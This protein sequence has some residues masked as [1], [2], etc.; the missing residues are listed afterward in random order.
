MLRAF[1]F[2]FGSL[3]VSSFGFAQEMTSPA[4]LNQVFYEAR[5]QKETQA[6]IDYIDDA[7]QVY[8]SLA[9]EEKQ[10]TQWSFKANTPVDAADA[11]AAALESR[12]LSITFMA[13][14]KDGSDCELVPRFDKP[15]KPIYNDNFNM[16]DIICSD[17]QTIELIKTIASADFAD[18]LNPGTNR[19]DIHFSVL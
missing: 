13:K 19:G 14:M 11:K 2:A 1:L 10:I 18:S 5:I 15:T 9:P 3:L 6:Q 16:M 17:S 12:K 8:N 4:D 7:V